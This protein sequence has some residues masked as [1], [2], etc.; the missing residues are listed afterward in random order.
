MFF[1]P[2]GKLESDTSTFTFLGPEI[3][4]PS[5]LDL[6]IVI[7]DKDS[8]ISWSF[9]FLEHILRPTDLWTTLQ[10]QYWNKGPDFTATAAKYLPIPP[11]NSV[12]LLQ[13]WNRKT[14]R[15]TRLPP[16]A[17]QVE[18]LRA[19][20]NRW[21]ST[22]KEK[23]TIYLVFEYIDAELSI[24]EPEEVFESAPQSSGI[25]ISENEELE[26]QVSQS[27]TPS[28]SPIVLSSEHTSDAENLEELQAISGIYFLVYP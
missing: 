27:E 9:F 12:Y 11:L 20:I 22:R 14:K 24:E 21:F 23:T 6:D 17:R 1:G 3:W 8:R 4:E 15:A 10:L 5:D 16:N 26:I 2:A 19:L 18:T 28:D 25:L 13:A 7:S